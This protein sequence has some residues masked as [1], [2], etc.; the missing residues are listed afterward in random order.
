MIDIAASVRP[1]RLA[2]WFVAAAIAQAALLLPLAGPA[3]AAEAWKFAIYV[4]GSS[5]LAVWALSVAPELAANARTAGGRR[6]LY[7]V[8]VI[9]MLGALIVS[10]YFA[11]RFYYRPV[12]LLFT[13]CT[14][15]L[16]SLPFFGALALTLVGEWYFRLPRRP[17]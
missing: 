17:R 14:I 6:M 10:A 1:S 3:D 8:A 5:A 13:A 7:A 16:A 4:A 2:L 15:F 12:A 11:Q 9:A